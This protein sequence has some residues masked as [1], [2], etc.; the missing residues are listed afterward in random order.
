MLLN[1]YNALN[2]TESISVTPEIEF[3]DV[4]TVFDILDSVKTRRV[5]YVDAPQ[6]KDDPEYVKSGENLRP[7][8]Q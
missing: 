4:K 5:V 1:F 3:G 6:P 7:Y 8:I 2:G